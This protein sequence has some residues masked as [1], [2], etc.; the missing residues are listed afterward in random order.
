MVLVQRDH[1]LHRQA[2][3]AQIVPG[4]Q[5]AAPGQAQQPDPNQGQSRPVPSPSG[6]QPLLLPAAIRP[7]GRGQLTARYTAPA[8]AHS[9][10]SPMPMSR[11]PSSPPRIQQQNDKE[12]RRGSGLHR[13][14]FISAAS[15]NTS[16]SQTAHW[17]IT[18]IAIGIPLLYDPYDP[19]LR[20]A[21]PACSP[22]CVPPAQCRRIGSSSRKIEGRLGAQHLIP[23]MGLT[24][25]PGRLVVRFSVVNTSPFLMGRAA[26]MLL[27]ATAALFLASLGAYLLFA[28]AHGHLMRRTACTMARSSSGFRLAFW[29]GA[30]QVFVQRKVL[31]D[32]HGAQGRGGH[33][34]LPAGGVI[35]KGPTGRPNWSARSSMAPRFASSHRGVGYWVLQ[36]SSTTPGQPAS[37]RTAVRASSTSLRMLMPVERIYRGFC[38]AHRFQIGQVGDLAAGHLHPGQLQR[39]PNST[40]GMS[41]GAERY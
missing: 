7:G 19:F 14:L 1:V 28:A 5:A 8:P 3:V 36:C 13:F 15:A 18:V 22:L 37:S 6:G 23:R 17:P 41:K 21:L 9:H 34:A 10:T 24:P 31:F 25:S 27:R 16:T 2:P 4:A 29:S 12:S 11:L 30:G 32:H 20:A 39:S 35:R 26:A 33:V 40:L 38:A